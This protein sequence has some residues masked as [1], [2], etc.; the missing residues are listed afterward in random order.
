VR[1]Y[2]EFLFLPTRSRN[3]KIGLQ[4]FPLFNLIS[5]HQMVMLL[6]GFSLVKNLFSLSRIKI[7]VLN[8]ASQ[9]RMRRRKLYEMR[10]NL[11]HWE[12]IFSCGENF[13]EGKIIQKGEIEREFQSAQHL[14]ED[15]NHHTG[16]AESREK[17]TTQLVFYH[18][19]D[20]TAARYPWKKII[21]WTKDILKKR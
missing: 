15:V 7:N 16:I 8:F 1:F 6:L 4:I 14:Y 3:I 13:F 18:R 11:H 2:P 20:R 19:L 21:L 10:W 17:C 9:K 5:E 12:S